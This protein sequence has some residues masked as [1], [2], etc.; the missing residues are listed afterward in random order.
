M[1]TGAFDPAAAE[2]VSFGTVEADLRD[3]IR[4][5]HRCLRLDG[6]LHI[7]EPTTYFEDIGAFC[8]RLGKL[9]FDVMAPK[10][11]GVFT[12]IYALRNAKRPDPGV[13]LPFSRH[14]GG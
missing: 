5:A 4:E 13:V 7:W 12:R 10:A 9:G 1:A 2:R 6:R 14:V 11:E 8:G 3:Y